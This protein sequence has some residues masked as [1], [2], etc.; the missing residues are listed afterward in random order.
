MV[1]FFHAYLQ[2][3]EQCCRI[4]SKLTYFFTACWLF[5]F[6]HFLAQCSCVAG[7]WFTRRKTIPL[8]ENR[9][10]SY[11]FGNEMHLVL[12]T[13]LPF[14]LDIMLLLPFVSTTILRTVRR[15]PASLLFT[16]PAMRAPLQAFVEGINV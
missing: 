5:W 14:A 3:W 13:A 2:T 10:P 8:L 1:R 11:F 6:L 15:W 4:Q 9:L 7:K 12:R 16:K